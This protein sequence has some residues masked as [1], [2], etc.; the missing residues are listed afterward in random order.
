MNKE[1]DEEIGMIGE[2]DARLIL[3]VLKN[4]KPAYGYKKKHKKAVSAIGEIVWTFDW[5]KH[6]KECDDFLKEY[7]AM[8]ASRAAL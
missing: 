4:L 6:Q 8:Q 7:R 3:E 2:S 5:E 1:L